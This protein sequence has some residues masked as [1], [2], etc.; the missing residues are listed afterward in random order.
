[1]TT[2]SARELGESR[3]VSRVVWWFVLS[4]GCRKREFEIIIV[5]VWTAMCFVSRN[6]E[7]SVGSVILESLKVADGSEA[8][9]D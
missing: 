5:N 6:D 1:M 7:G 8:L 9:K 4:D 2:G 3:M